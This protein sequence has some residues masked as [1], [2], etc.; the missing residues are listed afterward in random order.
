[1]TPGTP[2]LGMAAPSRMI[3]PRRWPRL[4]S[5]T[6]STST[7][8][9]KPGPS[10]MVSG[11]I[12][13]V[14]PRFFFARMASTSAA[15]RTCGMSSPFGSTI[16]GTSPRCQTTTASSSV[17]TRV[18]R[19]PSTTAPPSYTAS[20]TETW[21]RMAAGCSASSTST[22]NPADHSRWMVPVARSPPPRTR[23][24]SSRFIIFFLL[25]QLQEHVHRA[26][27]GSQRRIVLFCAGRILCQLTGRSLACLHF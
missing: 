17:F 12:S 3:R 18:A 21:R 1:M 5:T 25:E 27:A 13:R 4:V 26:A 22:F 9:V 14:V 2:V 23:M 6:R 15:G 7:P 16:T 19:I 10:A 8:A 11:A 24:T 20:L